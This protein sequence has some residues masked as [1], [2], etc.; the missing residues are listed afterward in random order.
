[1]KTKLTYGAIKGMTLFLAGI[2][3]KMAA[4]MDIWIAWIELDLA[5]HWY[6]GSLV[7]ILKK[8]VLL[9]ILLMK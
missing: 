4:H 2:R 6:D 9:A 5:N 3:R 1:M 7:L 8:S